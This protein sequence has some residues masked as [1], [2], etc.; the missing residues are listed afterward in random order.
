LLKRLAIRTGETFLSVI[1]LMVVVET[2]QSALIW[3]DLKRERDQ[4]K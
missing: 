3:R 2:V 4:I 1:C